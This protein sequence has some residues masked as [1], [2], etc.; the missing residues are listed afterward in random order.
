MASSKIPPRAGLGQLLAS[1]DPRKRRAYEPSV[2]SDDL[3]SWKYPV[4]V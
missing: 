1:V 4:K 2:I 3:L